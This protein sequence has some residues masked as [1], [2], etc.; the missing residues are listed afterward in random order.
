[1]GKGWGAV[2]CY[3]YLVFIDFFE[4]L[5]IYYCSLSWEKKMTAHWD[6]ESK[7]IRAHRAF[8]FSELSK[9][10][11][12][13]RRMRGCVSVWESVCVHDT[14][15]NIYIQ[16]ITNRASDRYSEHSKREYHEPHKDSWDWQDWGLTLEALPPRGGG[17]AECPKRTRGEWDAGVENK[18]TQNTQSKSKT[19]LRCNATTQGT[20]TPVRGSAGT[21]ARHLRW[22]YL[23]WRLSTN[24][25]KINIVVVGP[26]EEEEEGTGVASDVVK[27]QGEDPDTPG[28]LK[29]N[30]PGTVT[31]PQCWFNKTKQHTR[32]SS[33]CPGDAF[34]PLGCDFG[35]RISARQRVL[36]F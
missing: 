19:P 9:R 1:M 12:V 18:N 15:N 3:R 35:R 22:T 33:W 4:G 29:R 8:T 25:K 21:Q 17:R 10:E 6:L 34:S 5:C 31:I 14:C 26:F 28:L 11:K 20:Q 32:A 36:D 30:V 2:A 27:V 7:K 16:Y 24:Q 23:A 13:G